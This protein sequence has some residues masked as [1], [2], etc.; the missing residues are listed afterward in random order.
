MADTGAHAAKRTKMAEN[1]ASATGRS[2]EQWAGLAEEAGI[3]G[4]MATVDWLKTEH[5]LGHFQA[6]LVAEVRRDGHL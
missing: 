5:Q 4:F 6:R 1:L 3:E 2:V